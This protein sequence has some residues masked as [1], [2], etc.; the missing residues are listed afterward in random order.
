MMNISIV[1][2]VKVRQVSYGDKVTG[3][4]AEEPCAEMDSGACGVHTAD[5]RSME[6]AARSRFLVGQT[7]RFSTAFLRWV[8]ARGRDGLTYP[9][10]RLVEALHCGGPV[11]MRELAGQLGM[12]ARNVTAVV[13]S[14]EEAG[15][16]ARKPHPTDRRA[17]IVEL[18]PGGT[19]A[20]EAALSSSLDGMA[21]I[22]EGL[23]LEDQ[24]QFLDVLMRL[25]DAMCQARPSC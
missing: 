16:A 18:T 14:L 12:T 4:D 5:L 11:I 8:D 24:E 9:R 13:D 6:A 1:T 22:F 2:K 3:V 23:S 15:L 19:D 25:S 17:T 20:A 21:V 10:L 7:A